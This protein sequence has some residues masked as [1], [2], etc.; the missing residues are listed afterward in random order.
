METLTAILFS[1]IICVAAI[2]S[3]FIYETYCSL[4]DIGE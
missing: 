4:T 3:T 2:V 1:G